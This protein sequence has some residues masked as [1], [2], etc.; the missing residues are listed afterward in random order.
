MKK[1]RTWLKRALLGL[2]ALFIIVIGGTMTVAYMTGTKPSWYRTGVLDRETLAKNYNSALTKLG[3]MQNWAQ[4][5]NNWPHQSTRPRVATDPT[6]APATSQTIT[7]T[8]DELNAVLST[9]EQTLLE[10][11][12]HAISDPQIAI[13]EGHIVLAVTHKGSG[14]V[15]SLHVK[16]RLDAEGMFTLSADTLMAGKI[17]VPRALWS[18][19]TDQV[20]DM[21]SIKLEH[22]R[23]QA[24][25]E[26]DGTGNEPA[27]I[28]AMS[29]LVL[30]SLQDKA[31]DPV[32]FLPPDLTKLGTG[33]PVK[34]VDVTVAD[35]SLA[36]TLMPLD[37]QEQQQLLARLR[38]PVGEEPAPAITAGPRTALAQ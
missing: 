27:V 23:E 25:I 29:R 26:A 15:I 30:N 17:P 1:K 2:A 35:D 22:A 24:I 7:L 5:Q 19:Y 12:G 11:Y 38:A 9:Q 36:L 33:Y 34:I 14:R 8:E 18:S 21:L 10:R 32:L 16:P 3:N 31:S 4:A 28:S 6:T 13:H 37:S 20:R